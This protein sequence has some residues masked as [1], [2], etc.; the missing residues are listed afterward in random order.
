MK[1]IIKYTV[2]VLLILLSTVIL[3]IV[4]AGITIQTSYFKKKLPP[5]IEK[6]ASGYVTGTLTIKRIDGNLLQGFVLTDILLLDKQ[7][8]VAYI[9]K[10]SVSYR[11]FSLLTK[12]LEL[13]SANLESPFFFLKQ[14]NDS[15]WNIQHIVKPLQTKQ[16]DTTSSSFVVDLKHFYI[17]SGLIIIASA[18]TVIPKRVENLNIALSL[19]YSE[20]TQKINIQEFNLQTQEPYLLLR[21]FTANITRK[22][23]AIEIKDLIIKTALN[24]ITAQG[25][26]SPHPKV[27][28]EF[29]LCSE[30]LHINEFNYYIPGVELLA[31]P[32]FELIAHIRNDS[33][34]ASVQLNSQTTK[35]NSNT[36]ISQESIDLDLAL[37]NFPAIIYNQTDSLIQYE[38]LGKFINVNLANWGTSPEVNY[39]INGDI[40]AQGSGANPKTLITRVEGNL[41]SSIIENYKIDLLDFEIDVNKGNIKGEAIGIG[42]FGKIILT[43]VIKGFTNESPTYNV[44]LLGQ[45]LNLAV[46]TGNDSL[47]SN[48]N[49]RATIGGRGFNPKT[50]DAK[51]DIYVKKSQISTVFVDTLFA[52]MN[53][54]RENFLIDS[55]WLKTQSLT[56]KAKGNYSLNSSSN[57]VLL[58]YLNNLDEFSSLLPISGL[59]TSGQ[60]DARLWGKRDSL[61]LDALLKLNEFKYDSITTD[62]IFLKA[63][64]LLTQ[65]DTLINAELLV[66]NIKSSGIQIDSVKAIVTSSL[67][68]AFITGRIANIDF[69]TNF[70]T[71]IN[72][73]DKIRVRLDSWLIN[74]KGEQWSLQEAPATFVIDS[75]NYI[76]N[77]F[78]LASNRSDSSGYIWANGFYSSS[79]AE[80]LDLK[81]ANLSIDEIA[82][83][84]GQKID[85]TGNINVDLSLKGTAAYPKLIGNF[86]IDKP[87]FNEFVINSF[88]VDID[89]EL[90]RL[91]FNGEIVPKDS[92][93][94]ELAGELPMNLKLDKV[95][96]NIYSTRNVTANIIIDRFPLALFQIFNL[97]EE[98]KGTLDGS[99]SINGPI[100]SLNPF[101]S[102]HLT[103][104]SFGIP[105][106]GI[107]Y[108]KILFDINMQNDKI[109]VDTFRIDTRDGNVTA[110]G[111][112]YFI[113]D[114]YKGNLRNSTVKIDFDK[115]NPI[116]HKQLN[117]Q[118][119]GNASL[120]GESG[121][122]VFG[123]DLNIPKAEV[124]LPFLFNLLGKFNSPDI[125]KSILMQEI[126]RNKLL[127]NAPNKLHK[128]SSIADSTSK[129][130]KINDTISTN[131]FKNFTGKLKLKIP[132]NT[133]IKNDDMRIELSGDLELRKNRGFFELFGTV[134]VVRGQYDLFGK[135]F[136]IDEGTITLN[137]GEELVPSLDVTASY[138]FRNQGKVEQT[139]TVKASG[140]TNTPKI[141]FT[142]DGN[143]INE[144]DA[145]SYILFGKGLNELTLSQQDNISGSGK[146]NLAGN[147]AASLIS[148]QLTKFLGD[149]LDVDYIEIKGSGNFDNATVTIG[150][151][152]TKDIFISYEKLFGKTD[153][154]DV[155]KYEVKLEYLIFKYLF[156]QLNN[157]SSDSGFD[158]IFKIESK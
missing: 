133:W 61:N 7:D 112:I 99:G 111:Q 54:S 103:N 34:I 130:N 69:N 58:A 110:Q 91:K 66:N 53:Y 89:Y 134:D 9:P 20:K 77:N 153:Q 10:M 86:S 1:K 82:K 123:G 148:S 45:N 25:N 72:W 150:K 31:Y 23:E 43:P 32:T 95:N 104:A 92:G 147:A 115:F 35:E 138:R 75:T 65:N 154:K 81:I 107:D 100:S 125:P 64:A 30:P 73:S 27:R 13:T 85:A 84:A 15:T 42:D 74:Y 157:S 90:D 38:L 48:L 114:F 41:K 26:Y 156:L 51:V 141:D 143:Y 126:E 70:N 102:F 87:M 44:K 124:N 18:D 93:R 137:G 4:L 56:V 50:L 96:F 36:V 29:T 17:E 97:S 40:T 2:R 145:L 78:K 68:S 140:T 16:S 135:I 136:K 14:E 46:I 63:K 105:Q 146:S 49:L 28:G 8:T 122:V 22:Q 47:A 3:L 116:D 12:K 106:Y 108:R 131:Y 39:L 109:I 62:S 139:L 19:Y 59:K 57:I 158:V 119:S 149:K 33:L 52:N 129:L 55:L 94:I 60:L 142:L 76:V 151:Y 152:I 128:S 6:I 11:L 79:G 113:S 67:D 88:N 120:S 71:G 98:I 24:Q 117:V 132:R 80:G 118:L 21:D 37:A 155:D 5:I 144:G 101:G 121:H 127:Q 83:L